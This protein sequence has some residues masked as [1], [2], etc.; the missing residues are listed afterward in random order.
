M[1]KHAIVVPA[2]KH[3]FWVYLLFFFDDDDPS[4]VGVTD[5]FLKRMDEH[6][7]V[8]GGAPRVAVARSVYGKFR[9][10]IAAALYCTLLE[11]KALET[12]LMKSDE[13]ER[14]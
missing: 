10:K 3:H 11:A 13:A 1:P 9:A 2:T 12:Y 7:D 14:D 6:N 4:Y 8:R 5:N